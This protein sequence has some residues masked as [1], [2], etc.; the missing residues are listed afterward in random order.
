MNRDKSV[1]HISCP[2][3]EQSF[4][5]ARVD[6]KY[7]SDACRQ[8]ASRQRRRPPSPDELL[9]RMV[10]DFVARLEGHDLRDALPYIKLA[11]L[12]LDLA[13]WRHRDKALLVALLFKWVFGDGQSE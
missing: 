5:A 2:V 13:E 12:K 7:C 9:D 3:C 6:T 10:D 4:F 1:S 8:R 11:E